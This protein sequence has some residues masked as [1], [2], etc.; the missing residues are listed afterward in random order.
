MNTLKCSMVSATIV[1]L[2]TGWAAAAPAVVLDYLNL[3]VGPG[4][5]YG[6][7]E[8]IPSGWIV[9]AG[10]C[11]D[12]WCQVNVDGFAGYVDANYLGIAR[13]PVIAYGPP[14]YYW[15][16]G[17]YDGRYTYSTYPYRGYSGPRYDPNYAYD[18]GYDDDP[19]S[20]G[21]FAGAYAQQRDAGMRIDRRATAPVRS[22]AVAKSKATPHVAKVASNASTTG[23]A[24]TAPRPN[25]ADQNPPR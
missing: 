1:A 23:A 13:P 22:T 14:P 6:I 9:D 21:T 2:S 8:V 24:T 15:S 25:R 16:R 7:I 4:Y 19:L 3:R 12:G 5:G 10:A 17:P 11:G 20:P 18:D